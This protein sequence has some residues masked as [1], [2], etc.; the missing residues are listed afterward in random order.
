MKIVF[1]D[2]DG[3]LNSRRFYLERPSSEFKLD[4]VAVDRLNRLIQCSGANVVVSSTWRLGRSIRELQKVLGSYGF[5]GKVIGRTPQLNNCYRG[6]EIREW[7]ADHPDVDLESFVILDDD[8][9]MV[10]LALRQVQT[11]HNFGLCGRHV[12][13]AIDVLSVPI[14]RT[15]WFPSV[16]AADAVPGVMVDGFLRE[17]GVWRRVKRMPRSL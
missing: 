16:S 9:D 14:R 7:V 12:R 1:L 13:D 11:N 15:D 6:F 17:G 2:F 8:A 4:S 3:V 10:D 5:E